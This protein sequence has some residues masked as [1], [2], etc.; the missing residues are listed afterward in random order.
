[1]MMVMCGVDCGD[2]LMERKTVVVV[3]VGHVGG[4]RRSRRSETWWIWVARGEIV[5]LELSRGL[6]LLGEMAGLGLRPV[7]VVAVY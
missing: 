2:G 6:G 4:R 5:M 3:V 7:G 1:M